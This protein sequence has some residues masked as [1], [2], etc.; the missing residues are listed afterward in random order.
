MKRSQG[1]T[2]VELLV[3]IGII[4]LLISILLPALNKAREAANVTKCLSNLRQM[5]TA[6]T[7]MAAERRGYIQGT[8]EKDRMLNADPSRSRYL[9]TQ[10]ATG[11]FPRD[12]A[13]ALLPYLGDKSGKTFIESKEKSRVFVCPSDPTQDS[14]NPGYT[15]LVNYGW[16][17]VPNSYGINADITSVQ[18]PT[19]GLGYFNGGFNVGVYKGPNTRSAYPPAKRIGNPLSGKLTSVARSSETMLFADCGV[20]V[21]V[22]DKGVPFPTAENIP[23]PDTRPNINGLNWSDVLAYSTN[24]VTDNTSINATT[25]AYLY[26]TLEGV[27]RTDWLKRKIPYQ[28]HGRYTSVAEA[29]KR[30][31]INVVFADG[32]AESVA[33]GDFKRVRVSPYRF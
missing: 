11:Q 12:W 30:G 8:A 31:R 18:D 26:G 4:A 1:F 20:R 19:N 16:G 25:E 3:V 22:D 13:S 7:M 9:W 32:H 6:A 15:M 28:R 27:A 21:A 10:D 5:G 17:Y 2:L 24:Y 14:D 33:R 23:A 29:E